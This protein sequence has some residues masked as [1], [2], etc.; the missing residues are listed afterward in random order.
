[1]LKDIIHKKSSW[2]FYIKKC[3]HIA[4]FMG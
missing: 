3:W 4:F 2:F 1:M